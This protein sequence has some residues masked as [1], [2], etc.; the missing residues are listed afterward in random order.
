MAIVGYTLLI[1]LRDKS[2][3]A[4]YVG[5]IL[6]AMGAF[7]MS[8]IKTSWFSN[9]FAGHMRKSVAIALLTSLGNIGGAI[10]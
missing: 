6:A 7:G 9:N 1:T 3:A 10:G 4:L 8:P 2:A 5:S